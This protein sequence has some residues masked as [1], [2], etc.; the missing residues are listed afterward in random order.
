MRSEIENYVKK[1]PS[2]QKNKTYNKDSMKVPMQ[3]SNKLLKSMEQC[4]LENVGQL[5]VTSQGNIYI[6]Y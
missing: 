2:C 6:L 4:A 1:C 3:I 5:A